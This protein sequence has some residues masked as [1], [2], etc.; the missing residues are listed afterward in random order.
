MKNNFAKI[1][2]AYQEKAVF[3]RQLGIMLHS[4]IPISS[5]LRQMQSYTNL[6]EIIN[7]LVTY[8]EQGDLLS[9]AM[10]KTGYT[11][12]KMEIASISAGEKSGNLPEVAGRLAGYFETLQNVKNK[13]IS[14]MIYPAILLHAAIIIPAIPLIFTKS[15]FAFFIRILP[16]FIIIYGAGFA[17]FFVKKTLSKPEMIKIRDALALKLPAGFGKLFTKISVVRFLQAFNCLYSA[18]ISLIDSIRISAESSG[19]KVIEEELLKAIPIVQE[20]KNLSYAFARNPYLPGI[21]IDMFS[22][23]EISGNLDETLEKAAWHLQQ[24]VDLAV[25][26]ILKIV[27]VVVY[28]I[29]ALYVAMIII[30]FYANYFSQINSLLE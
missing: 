29:V 25:E 5:A 14:G 18:G 1:L 8:V 12:S 4:G 22:T 10:K 13:L 6:N 26:A 7:I 20:G 19:N 17:I 24:E 27:P 21:V 3:Y 9:D 15:I 23:G 11:F 2:T 28:L 30:S 16:P